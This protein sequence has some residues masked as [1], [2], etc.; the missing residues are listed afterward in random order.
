M[1]EAILISTDDHGYREAKVVETKVVYNKKR[2]QYSEYAG[3][4]Y[5]EDGD[6]IVIRLVAE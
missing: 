2:R 3:D 5:L 4:E 1:T 6:E